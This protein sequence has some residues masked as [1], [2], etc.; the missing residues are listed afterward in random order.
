[1]SKKLEKLIDKYTKLLKGLNEK[2]APYETFEFNNKSE[3]DHDANRM[4]AWLSGQ[5]EYCADILKDLEGLR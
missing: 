2:M 5:E 4:I 1:M 3:E